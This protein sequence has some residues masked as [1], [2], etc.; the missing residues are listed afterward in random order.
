[1]DFHHAFDFTRELGKPVSGQLLPIE[2]LTAIHWVHRIGAFITLI[3]AGSFALVC[4]TSSE[5]RRFALVLLAL[6]A[7]QIGLGIT[8]VLAYLPL[9]VA[10]A[11]NGV[12]ALLLITVMMLNFRINSSRA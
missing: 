5:L 12:A 8:N 6:L 9:P 2:S 1:M 4:I 10:I 11:H 3:I 7:L